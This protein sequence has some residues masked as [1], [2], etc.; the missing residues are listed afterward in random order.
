MSEK[1]QTKKNDLPDEQPDHDSPEQGPGSKEADL[2]SARI[3]E[4]ESTLGQYKDQLLRKAAEFD[5]YKKRIDNDYASIIRY[6]NEELI[7]K[8]LPVLDDFERSFR[9][10]R[11]GGDQ[12]NAVP[13]PGDDSFRRGTELIYNKFRKILE[14]QGI[15]PIEALGKPFDPHLHDALLQIPRNDVPPHTVIEEVDKG[16]MLNDRVLRHAKVVVAAD[17]PA[18]EEEPGRVGGPEREGL[19]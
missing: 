17:T 4:L 13:S 2:L 9:A 8:L 19:S 16:Y 6:S 1:K 11:T 10:A 7:L 5:N 18:G 14:A 12:S 3:A 15:R